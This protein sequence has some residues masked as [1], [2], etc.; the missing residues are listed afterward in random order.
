[1]SGAK[2]GSGLSQCYQ[3]VIY[4]LVELLMNQDI[5]EIEIDVID[6]SPKEKITIRGEQTHYN[7]T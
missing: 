1:M 4:D 5:I 7:S 2:L 3:R 6:T